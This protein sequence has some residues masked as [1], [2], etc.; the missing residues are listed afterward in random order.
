MEESDS[1]KKLSHEVSVSEKD[2]RLES[3]MGKSTS[4][5]CN[6]LGF[7]SQHPSGDL[8]P[9]LTPVKGDLMPSTDLFGHQANTCYTHRQNTIHL[10]QIIFK[11]YFKTNKPKLIFRRA[12]NY[13]TSFQII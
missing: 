8:Q 12:N 4:C 3:S 13:K 9:S 7:S 6:G 11:K 1:S 10:K 2:E 5:S